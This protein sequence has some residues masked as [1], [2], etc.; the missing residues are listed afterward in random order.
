MC[1]ATGH[2]R[3]T[4]NSDRESGHPQ[5]VMSALPPEADVCSANRHVCFGPIADICRLF[6]HLVGARE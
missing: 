4:L 2:V 3:F 1:N 6:G 5:K